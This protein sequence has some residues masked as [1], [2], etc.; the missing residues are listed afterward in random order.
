[1]NYIEPLSP[2]PVGNWRLALFFVASSVELE[3]DEESIK[4]GIVRS[5]VRGGLDISQA[6]L[7]PLD[8]WVEMNGVP[9][10][11]WAAYVQNTVHGLT[12]VQFIQRTTIPAL[13]SKEVVGEWT[14]DYLDI[15]QGPWG[16]EVAA[17][18]PYIWSTPDSPL[19]IGVWYS[20]AAVWLSGNVPSAE[21]LE[22][23]LKAGGYNLYSAKQAIKPYYYKGQPNG[24]QFLVYTGNRPSNV[25][26]LMH[27][28]GANQL[29]V[30]L[31]API[32]DPTLTDTDKAFETKDEVL[33]AISDLGMGIGEATEEVAKGTGTVVDVM[34]FVGK[35]FLPIVVIGGAGYLFYKHRRKK[36]G[37]ASWAAQYEDF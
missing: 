24:L 19:Q 28:I 32:D 6:N 4:N 5:A 27:A 8:I 21:V 37:S 35:Y 12:T 25:R 34:G 14:E 22:T 11:V 26:K 3:M 13:F 7:I 1:M 33:S 36:G 16:A 23:R 10:R 31:A 9:S 30:N 15:L 18:R 17:A 20:A 2:I 29:V